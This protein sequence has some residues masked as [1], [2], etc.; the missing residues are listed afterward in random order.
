[1]R[2]GKPFWGYTC[3]IFFGICAVVFA[4]QMLPM[5][6]YLRLTQEGFTYCSLFRRHT[7][8]WSDVT[9]FSVVRVGR[10]DMVTWD[11]APRYKKQSLA[12]AVARGIADVE[13]ALPDTYGMKAS[14]LAALM[15]TLRLRHRQADKSQ[16]V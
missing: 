13:G 2:T 11:V 9:S 16:R 8:R 12:R 7:F 14:A 15:D 4:L 6:S 1:M 5:S 3:A 10:N